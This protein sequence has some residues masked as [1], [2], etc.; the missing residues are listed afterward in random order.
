MT[1]QRSPFQKLYFSKAPVYNYVQQVLVDY[2][3]HPI[4]ENALKM[5]IS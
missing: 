3:I 4:D 1:N 2:V 5:E